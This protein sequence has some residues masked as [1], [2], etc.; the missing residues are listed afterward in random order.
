MMCANKPNTPSYLPRMRAILDAQVASLAEAAT[1]LGPSFDTWLA[2]EQAR[3]GR[4]GLVGVGKSGLIAE[5]LAATFASTGTPAFWVH[6]TELMHGDLGRFCPGDG[7]LIVSNSGE[8]E[9]VVRAAHAL[10]ST[11][12]ATSALTASCASRLGQSVD[13]CLAVGW[14]QEVDADGRIPTASTLRILAM[15]DALAVCLMEAR[16][17]GGQDFARLHPGGLLGRG[18][19]PVR[20][21][22]RKDARA[23]MFLATDLLRDAVQAMG[24]APGRPGAVLVVNDAGHLQGIFTDGDLRRGVLEGPFCL[25]RPLLEVMQPNPKSVN[26]DAQV[27][28]VVA[29]MRAHRIDQVAVVDDAGCAVGLV[30]VQ[31]LIG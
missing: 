9:E 19:V 12:I 14:A 28:A 20:A 4:L 31:D 3:L 17:F 11:S 8:S 27:E 22:M 15:G 1:C 18:F 29:L 5:K 16:N 21:L 2:L 6:A 7:A 26:I 24:S 13:V 25:E 23:P 10:R 30:D